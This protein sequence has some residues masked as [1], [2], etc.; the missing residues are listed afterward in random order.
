MPDWMQDALCAETDPEIFFPEKGQSSREAKLICGQCD[1]RAQ[2]LDYALEDR[3]LLG[4]WG[5]TAP[6]EREE[7]R[8]QQRRDGFRGLYATGTWRGVA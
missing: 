8:K 6:R 5:G 2:C 1:V 4:V 3:D 7:I